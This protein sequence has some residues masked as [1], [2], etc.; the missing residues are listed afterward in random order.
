[1]VLHADPIPENGAAG[2]WTRRINGYN[3]DF[4]A[5]LSKMDRQSID[6]GRLPRTGRACDPENLRTTGQG[7]ELLDELG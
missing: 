2:E 1:M 7:V 3:R 6:E 5:S 4:E